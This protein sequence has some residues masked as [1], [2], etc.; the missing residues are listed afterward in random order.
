MLEFAVD[1]R[2]LAERCEDIGTPGGTSSVRM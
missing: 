2:M 1:E